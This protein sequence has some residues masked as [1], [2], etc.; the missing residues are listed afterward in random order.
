[1]IQKTKQHSKTLCRVRDRGLRFRPTDPIA[2]NGAC[3]VSP[4][5]VNPLRQRGARLRYCT[6]IPLA[7]ELSFTV[8][9]WINYW[10]LAFAFSVNCSIRAL[11]LAPA[12]ANISKLV[13][14]C[15]PLMLTLNIREPAEDRG[16]SDHLR[17]LF[18]FPFPTSLD[19]DPT[20]QGL[21]H[22]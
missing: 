20:H 5:F 14:T 16:C 19:L 21:I 3:C 2:L 9:H 15:V 8:V 13:N 7:R 22:Y 6:S 11:F 1:M 12:L 18:P 10:P 4:I 17:F